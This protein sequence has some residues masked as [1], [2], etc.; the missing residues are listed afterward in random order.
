MSGIRALDGAQGFPEGNNKNKFRNKVLPR[1]KGWRTGSHSIIKATR[2]QRS[3]GVT[4]SFDGEMEKRR[5]DCS[6]QL[7]LGKL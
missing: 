1:G 7:G 3:S 2:A 5:K 6:S 4:C